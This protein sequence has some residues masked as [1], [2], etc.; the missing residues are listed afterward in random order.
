M[1]A[2][3]HI[4]ELKEIAVFQGQ[5]NIFYNRQYPSV[6]GNRTS[7][8]AGGNSSV[9]GV[10]EDILQ[11]REIAVF[12]E[13]LFQLRGIVCQGQQNLFFTANGNSSV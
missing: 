13:H 6:R 4:L 7:F 8:T 12:Q 1:R 5:R 3:E 9:S 11:L 2:T 10:R